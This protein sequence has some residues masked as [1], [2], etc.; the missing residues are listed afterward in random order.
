MNL[1]KFFKRKKSVI[2]PCCN[3][4]Y[5]TFLPFGTPPRPNARCANCGSLERQRLIW[6]FLK[7]QTN[8][9]KNQLTLLH[10]APEEC[11]FKPIS[12]MSN[13][14]YLPVDMFTPGHSYPAGTL[15]MDITKLD[16][17]DNSIDAVLCVHVLEHIPDDFQALR[18]LLRVLKPTGW[19]ILQIPLN[20]KLA[21]THEDSSITD[22]LE[23]AKVFGQ[24]DHVR[25]YG[26]DYGQRLTKAGFKVTVYTPSEKERRKYVLD[27]DLYFCTHP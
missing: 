4:R 14:K 24:W 5:E 13:I 19:A 22:P 20:K 27:E 8:F 16:L 3:S 26:R 18:E 23:R 7:K 1:L 11:F 10:V 25:M 9:F 17:K 15:N 21:T 6:Y 2:C 12:K